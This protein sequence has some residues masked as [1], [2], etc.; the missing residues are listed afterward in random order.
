MDLSH[1]EW[2]DLYLDLDLMTCVYL[3]LDLNF[4]GFARHC[5]EHREKT[6]HNTEN[7]WRRRPPQIVSVL[8]IVSSIDV[9]AI[10]I[11]P[12]QL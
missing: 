5:L 3:D 6:V 2:V 11:N 12:D 8:E 7:L 1:F 4:T 9:G 10:Q